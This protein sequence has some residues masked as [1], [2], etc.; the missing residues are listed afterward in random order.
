MTT[1]TP[2]SKNTFSLLLSFYP[3]ESVPIYAA[4]AFCNHIVAVSV[5]ANNSTTVC[6]VFDFIKQH[7]LAYAPAYNWDPTAHSHH[8]LLQKYCVKNMNVQ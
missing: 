4:A 6:K 8:I 5:L 2:R 7:Q 3:L 1:T